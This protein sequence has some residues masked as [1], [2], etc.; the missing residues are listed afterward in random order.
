MF[1]KKKLSLALALGLSISAGGYAYAGL[2]FDP[3][4][5]AF[6]GLKTGDLTLANAAVEAHA[7]VEAKRLALEAA[8]ADDTS[9]LGEIAAAE[10]ALEDAVANKASLAG[11]AIVDAVY[12]KEDLIV[13]LKDEKIAKGVAATRLEDTYDELAAASTAYGERKN[14][15]INLALKEQAYDADP[16]DEN[17]A[18][19]VSAVEAK[20]EFTQELTDEQT[21]EINEVVAAFDAKEAALLAVETVDEQ[22]DELDAT[23]GAETLLSDWVV[24]LEQVEANL[25][26]ELD[27]EVYT[28]SEKTSALAD[29][30]SAFDEAAEASVEA[31]VFF[32]DAY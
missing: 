21:S 30:Q 7:L 8:R 2:E 32:D 17:Y 12:A 27:S 4:N 9:T 20:A 31:D 18:A 29:A 10:D 25:E 26:A 28:L 24:R 19:Y 16:T 6:E 14:L 3:D 13:A 1:K 11:T 23:N 5:T 22:I 15:N